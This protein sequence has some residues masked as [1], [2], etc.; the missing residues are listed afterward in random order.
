MTKKTKTPKPYVI[1][2]ATNAGVFAGTLQSKTG[3]EVTLTDCRRIWQW[4]GAASLSQLAEEGTNDPA[5]CKFPQPVSQITVL[6]VI[7]IITATPKAQASI[8]SVPVWKR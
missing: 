1:I 3:D 5:G 7:E 6:G 8:Q 2:R 4:S